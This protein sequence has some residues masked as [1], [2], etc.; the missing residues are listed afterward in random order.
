[1][2]V[3]H[4]CLVPWCQCRLGWLKVQRWGSVLTGAP[5]TV[6]SAALREVGWRWWGATKMLGAGGEVILGKA[7]AMGTRL[8]GGVA[9]VRGDLVYACRHGWVDKA[10]GRA[11]W[12]GREVVV[13]VA[14]GSRRRRQVWHCMRSSPRRWPCFAG[15]CGHPGRWCWPCSHCLALHGRTLCFPH[16]PR[17]LLQPMTERWFE[18][19]WRDRGEK[20]NGQLNFD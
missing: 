18:R 2:A 10:D 20:A 3:S 14:W 1:M 4:H 13:L 6:G 11:G 9:V 7:G 15:C 17:F 16:P 19:G 5:P 8:A 12:F